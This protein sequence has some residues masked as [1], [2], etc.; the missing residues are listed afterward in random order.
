MCVDSPNILYSL[1]KD[2]NEIFKYSEYKLH[3]LELFITLG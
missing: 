1:L 2:Y 3:K